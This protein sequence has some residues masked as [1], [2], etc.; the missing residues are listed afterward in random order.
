MLT[1]IDFLSRSS[2]AY[3]FSIPLLLVFL[4]LKYDDRQ[5]DGSTRSLVYARYAWSTTFFV[6]LFIYEDGSSVL[7]Y[8]LIWVT[9]LIP[10]AIT[11]LKMIDEGS[12][13]N[14]L[15]LRKLD[16]LAI[17]R[18]VTVLAL[19][20]LIVSCSLMIG[21]TIINRGVVIETH[22]RLV[23]KISVSIDPKEV[24]MAQLSPIYGGLEIIKDIEE[25]QGGKVSIAYS[26]PWRMDVVVQT[27]RSAKS[28]TWKFFYIRSYGRWEFQGLYEKSVIG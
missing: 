2:G 12:E 1:V 10:I 24:L 20:L 7:S 16:I 8:F 4:S 11:M 23:E 5:K 21:D 27:E 14:K 18:K 25:I 15:N 13:N 22:K 26:T 6:G 17:P 3:I 28:T 9:I 19:V